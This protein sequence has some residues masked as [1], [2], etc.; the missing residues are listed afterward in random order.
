MASLIFGNIGSSLLGPI[1]GFIG[2]AIGSYIDNLLFAPKPE[3]IHGPRLED[4][5][6][7]S[8]DPGVAIPI[9]YGAD[10][11]PGIVVHTTDLIETVHKEELGG[12]GG[13]TQDSY[14][15]TYHVDI[16]YM[17]CEGPIMGVARI[18]SDGRLIR[19]TEYQ[20]D[21]DTE[22]NFEKI[23]G[24]PYSDWYGEDSYD[25]IFTPWTYDP[26]YIP[27][28]GDEL[29]TWSYAE[30]F[31]EVTL[32]EAERL[33]AET[34]T[35][36]YSYDSDS[37][38]YLPIPASH[39]YTGERLEGEGAISVHTQTTQ[40]P[41]ISESAGSSGA[42][43]SGTLLT[44]DTVANP[45]FEPSPTDPLPLVAP[46]N[47]TILTRSASL[48]VSANIKM[49]GNGGIF[50]ADTG[51]NSVVTA[52][53]S[54]TGVG[55]GEPVASESITVN[56]PSVDSAINR[57]PPNPPTGTINLELGGDVFSGG[58]T[59]IDYS[60]GAT[61][62]LTLWDYTVTVESS[63]TQT[64]TVQENTPPIRDFPD[65]YNF[66]DAIND[67]S[68]KSVFQFSGPEGVAFYPGT[69]DQISDPTM[70]LHAPDPDCGVPA[71]I[72]RAHIVLQRFELED[73]GNRIPNLTFEVV[74]SD[75]TR[76]RDV[77]T[78]LMRRAEIDPE[79]Y[80]IREL[81]EVD[82]PSYVL[83]YTIGTVTSYRAAMEPLL[84]AYEIDSAEIGDK[85]VFR[86]KRRAVDHTIDYNDLA[87][88]ESGSSPEPPLRLA[89]RDPIEMPVSLD[90]R[91]KDPEREYQPSTSRFARQNAPGTQ[92]SMIELPVVRQPHI[93]KMFTRD[94]I[95]DLWLERVSASWALPPKYTYISPSDIVKI[96]NSPE[97]KS[98]YTLKVVQSS[99]R[100]D[101]IVEFE[102]ARQAPDIYVPLSN[103]LENN[104]TQMGLVN[105]QTVINRLTFTRHYQLNLPALRIQDNSPGYYFALTGSAA[106]WP[107]GT[108]YQLVGLTWEEIIATPAGAR[109][110]QVSSFSSNF[111]KTN[112]LFEIDFDSTV[113]VRLFN[114]AEQLS[115]VNDDQFLRLTNIAVI[116]NEIVGFKNATSLGSGLWRLDTFLRARLDTHD[117]ANEHRNAEIFMILDANEMENISVDIS[118]L[119]IT[120][121]YG[122]VTF[123]G[124]LPETDS[125]RSFAVTD[126]RLKP[127][128]PVMLQLLE[129]PIPADGSALTASYPVT[130][131]NGDA[132]TGDFTGWTAGNA[133]YPIVTTGGG[134]DVPTP[135]EGTYMFEGG[136]TGGTS[137]DAEM[138]Q[139]LS[140][141]ASDAEKI[142]F[143][144]LY[145]NFNWFTMSDT[146]G[147][148]DQIK[149]RVEFLNSSQDVIGRC[150]SPAEDFDSWTERQYHV[151]PPVGT[152]AYTVIF[153]FITNFGGYNDATVDNIT[154][155]VSEGSI[156]TEMTVTAVD[157]A[158]ESDTTII[159]WIRQNRFNFN[160][161]NNGGDIPNDEAF[162]RYE[163]DI[164]APDTSAAILR[165]FTV[166]NATSVGYSLAQRTADG[167]ASGDTIQIA[168]YQI[169]DVVGRGNPAI[170]EFTC[171]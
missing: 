13:P 58:Y 21:L 33:L 38:K 51:H 17:L 85:I 73:F 88:K 70:E 111:N 133:A 163:V 59:S 23:G 93:M 62:G 34:T 74:Q 18:W 171:P 169:S 53:L 39:A 100:D 41:T 152:R 115:S 146:G 127:F 66:Y 91:F 151:T 103:E 79:L 43:F 122:S 7:V 44:Y 138:R 143:G 6:G 160:L 96:I 131:V 67:F 147:I 118:E 9:V 114:P 121:Q 154:T 71:Y 2:S 134:G 90:V 20:L 145:I 50:G 1:G 82:V 164:S 65:Y 140:V 86:P 60:V 36:V 77:I 72:G 117:H 102:G 80:D 64:I 56:T 12:K 8:A 120:E 105:E 106:S 108:L 37:E 139:T 170:G 89:L 130:L 101:G 155:A 107:G 52:S 98:D 165:T 132:E 148:D 156:G 162:E 78:D 46:A 124:G 125:A 150:E 109:A 54:M 31:Q 10:R 27:T 136:P 32:A 168:V 81:P 76:I 47:T 45:F 104:G 166:D 48:S 87:A 141:L 83:G 25:P 110:G 69:D 16:D 40:L 129:E 24:I 19:G 49:D 99:R 119:G 11:L 142:D 157:P 63:L 137:T 94:K 158:V 42:S 29:F 55:L 75:N 159:K 14:T 22:E 84:E 153:D 4:L 95:R 128:S 135:Y 116:G 3:D 68:P 144:L 126:N 30:G 123:G 149:L 35:V 61:R 26:T 167:F 92:S 161:Q 112:Q 28:I 97:G 5:T 113:T 57:P 15:Y